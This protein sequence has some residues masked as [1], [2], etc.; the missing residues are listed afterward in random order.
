MSHRIGVEPY[1]FA[2]QDALFVKIMSIGGRIS[3]FP[4]VKTLPSLALA[5]NGT[6]D[7]VEVNFGSAM[8]SVNIDSK[9]ELYGIEAVNTKAELMYLSEQDREFF[10]KVFFDGISD[11]LEVIKVVASEADLEGYQNQKKLLISGVLKANSLLVKAE[12]KLIFEV[13]KLIGDQEGLYK[14]QQRINPVVGRYAASYNRNIKVT[15]PAGYQLKNIE[16][17]NMD[18]EERIDSSSIMKFVVTAEV[19]NGV[20]MIKIEESYQGIDFPAIHFKLFRRVINA[21]ADFNKKVLI[22]EKEN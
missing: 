10:L 5:E 16:E 19:V 14:E 2:G 17:L 9:K 1:Q 15:V 6:F 7:H 21:A 8:N 12:D 13:G 20:L 3:A 22:L 4:Q 18:V 11:E